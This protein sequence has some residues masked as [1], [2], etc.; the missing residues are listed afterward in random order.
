VKL[1]LNL[2]QPGT[3]T[4]AIIFQRLMKA[5][6]ER[7]AQALFRNADLANESRDRRVAVGMVI[8]KN[9]YGVGAI[10]LELGRP[11]MGVGNWFKINH[12]DLFK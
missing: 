5:V 6:G 12:G 1:G 3:T 9:L 7:G 8:Q 10:Q 11:W 4:P 2:P